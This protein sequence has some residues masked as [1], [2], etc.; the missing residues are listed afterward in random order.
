[1]SIFASAF[2][3]FSRHHGLLPFLSEPSKTLMEG[4]V[5]SRDSISCLV[6]RDK[7]RSRSSEPAGPRFSVVICTDNRLE[8]LERTVSSLPY[9]DYEEFEVCV[10]AGPTEDG[11]RGYLAG[12]SGQIKVAHCDKRNLSRSRNIGIALAAGDIVAFID[13]DAIPE[14]EWLGQLAR[15]YDDGR[16]GA[17][18]GA[19][20]DHIGIEYQARYVTVDRLGRPRHET[21]PTPEFNFPGS[22]RIPHLLGTNC[23]FRRSALIAIGG[24]DE[25]YEYFLDETDVCCRINDAGHRIVQRPDAFVH[26]KYERS[27]LR[28]E[29][30]VVRDWYSI[31]KNRLYYGL[32]HARDF[33]P[34][35]EIVEAGLAERAFWEQDVAENVRQGRLPRTDAQRFEDQSKAAIEDGLRLA[36]EEPL[37]LSA[38]R[39]QLHRT[40]FRPFQKPW[41]KHDFRTL[42][43]LDGSAG[44]DHGETVDGCLLQAARRAAREGD[45]VHF[46]RRSAGNPSVDFEE[47]VWM[48]DLGPAADLG[49]EGHGSSL[50]ATLERIAERRWID[51]AYCLTTDRALLAPVAELLLRQGSESGRHD[52]EANA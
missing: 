13:D 8:H 41:V 22:A 21:R 1:M 48:H 46:V 31:I 20:H 30:K 3:E 47:G 50:C 45:R 24:F 19:V 6:A 14:P 18:G 28:D 44:S 52:A 7:G 35:L 5:P 25:T 23:S 42:V 16:V 11:T 49:R 9:Q 27:A 37:L 51:F 2:F 12:L 15:S 39:L 10:V 34:E 43:Y 4:Y 38:K 32:R 17:V 26:H 36:M 40:D 29:R 33:F